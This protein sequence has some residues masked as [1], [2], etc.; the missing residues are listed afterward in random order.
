MEVTKEIENRFNKLR[1]DGNYSDLGDFFWKGGL[2]QGKIR[3]CY[4][5][6]WALL[7]SREQNKCEGV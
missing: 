2:E 6:L 3:D 7:T 5:R 4:K 1:G